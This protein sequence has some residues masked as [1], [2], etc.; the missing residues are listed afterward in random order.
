[1]KSWLAIRRVFPDPLGPL[2]AVA[3]RESMESHVLDGRDFVGL[4]R[5]KDLVDDILEPE[6]KCSRDSGCLASGS[7]IRL[8]AQIN[9]GPEA[10][11]FLRMALNLR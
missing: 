8:P 3:F 2:R 5:V 11:C 4:A 1:M 10:V 7:L 9:R 6:G